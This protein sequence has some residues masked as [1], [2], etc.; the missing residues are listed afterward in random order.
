MRQWKHAGSVCAPVL[1]RRGHRLVAVVAQ[2][3][4]LRVLADE[5]R[6]LDPR[7]LGEQLGQ[8]QFGAL[9]PRRHIAALCAPWETVAHRQDR[10]GVLVIER[11]GVDAHPVAQ[12]RTA[13]IVPWHATRMRVRARRLANDEKACR[14]ARLQNRTSA[15]RQLRLARAARAHCSQQPLERLMDLA[16][17]DHVRVRFWSR[18]V[19][20]C[21]ASAT[22]QPAQAGQLTLQ[23]HCAAGAGAANVSAALSRAG[24][25]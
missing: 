18:V 23:R 6:E 22:R 24:A 8:P 14:R 10:N 11:C 20:R 1:G 16:D 2:E 5:Q 4:G 3:V 15:E 17:R 9:S 12:A 7:Q 13:A 25:A 21:H 19:R